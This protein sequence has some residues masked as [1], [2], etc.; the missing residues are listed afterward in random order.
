[1]LEDVYAVND[2]YAT[3]QGEGVFTGVPMVFLRLM[4][5]TVGCPWCDTKET[6]TPQ[7][8]HEVFALKPGDGKSGQWQRLPAVE[9]AA[10]LR[11]AYPFADWVCLTGGEPAEQNLCALVEALHN[12]DFRVA[13][14]TSGT[15]AGFLD[16]HLDHVCVSPKIDMPGG[17]RVLAEALN[18]ADEVKHVVGVQ[19]DIVR[20]MTLLRST[21]VKLK[22]DC[23][24]CL[25]PVSQSKKA[26]SLCITAC[27]QRN[28]RL[29]IQVHKYI[30]LA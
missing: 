29:S 26:T 30:G 11:N 9:I 20:L 10:M 14:E 27:Q 4:G 5:C 3:I 19:R 7:D 8:T 13:L 28:W 12:A 17:K 1:M 21:G 6:W 23:T 16:A 2:F 24:I 18:A 15:A 22:E 25:Q